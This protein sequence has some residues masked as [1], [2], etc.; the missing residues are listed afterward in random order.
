MRQRVKADT[1]KLTK[2]EMALTEAVEADD[3]IKLQ[4]ALE[5]SVK[6]RDNSYSVSNQLKGHY[7]NSYPYDLFGSDAFRLVGNA[8]RLACKKNATRCLNYFLTV[9]PHEFRLHQRCM[10]DAVNYAN[11]E[12]VKSL[13][14]FTGKLDHDLIV[15]HM[16]TVFMDEGSPEPLPILAEN[17]VK[18]R[19][20]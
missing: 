18:E 1:G 8:M 17:K 9:V 19:G 16:T 6:T 12:I 20:G 15:K 5:I 14:A 7:D 3:P 11:P 4:E 13:L 2:I 10:R